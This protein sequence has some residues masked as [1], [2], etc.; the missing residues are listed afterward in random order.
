MLPAPA[1]QGLGHG[2]PRPAGE[3]RR[4]AAAHRLRT[5]SPSARC[6]VARSL[7]LGTRDCLLRGRRVVVE[8]AFHSKHVGQRYR[9]AAVSETVSDVGQ[10]ARYLVFAQPWLRHLAMEPVAV[11]GH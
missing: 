10:Y 6:A 1:A 11:H 9:V 7:F 5:A 4:K 8:L 2:P 3:W